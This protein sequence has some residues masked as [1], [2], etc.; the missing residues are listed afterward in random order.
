MPIRITH[1]TH[2][3]IIHHTKNIKNV[4]TLGLK[5]KSVNG[6]NRVNKFILAPLMRQIGHNSPFC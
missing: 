3:T 4:N 2:V 1:T 6:D 5:V